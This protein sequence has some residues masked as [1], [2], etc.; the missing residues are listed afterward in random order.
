M[1][2][3]CYLIHCLF[4]LPHHF[5]TMLFVIQMEKTSVK[6]VELEGA[7]CM[8]THHFLEGGR[9]RKGGERE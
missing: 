7:H 6:E 5:I 2:F 4:N 3:Y 1:V 9:V 8:R